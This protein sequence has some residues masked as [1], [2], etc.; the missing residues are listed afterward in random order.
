MYSLAQDMRIWRA[1]YRLTQAQ[2]ADFAGVSLSSWKRQ[3]RFMSN[4][5]EDV[6]ERIATA[7][8]EEP[9]SSAAAIVRGASGKLYQ[10]PF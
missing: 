2:A 9:G 5:S 8:A 7:L 1:K 4:P 3:E 6:Y 10:V